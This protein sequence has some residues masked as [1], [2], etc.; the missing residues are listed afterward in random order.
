MRIQTNTKWRQTV[1]AVLAFCLIIWNVRSLQA[2]GMPV[3]DRLQPVTSGINAP[4]AVALDK[5]GSLYVAESI[6]KRVHIYSQGG[7]LKQTIQGFKS[8]VSV[9]V[10]DFGRIYVGDK[11]GGYVAVYD[12]GLGFQFK[13]G[14]GDGEF[15][16]PTDIEI[17]ST[18]RVYVVDMGSHIVRIYSA[19]GLYEGLIGGPGSGTTPTPDGKFSKPTSI[20]ISDATGEITVLDHGLTYDSYGTLVDGARIQKFN[21]DGSFKS[22]FSKFGMDMLS[23]EMFRPQHLAMDDH[24]RMYVTDTFYNVA[25]VYGDDGDPANGDTDVYLGAVYDLDVPLRIPIGITIG[26]NNKLYIASLTANRVDVFGIETYTNMVVSPLNLTYTDSQCAVPG[27]QDVDIVNNGTAGLDWTAVTD[28]SWIN[29]SS[30]SGSAPVSGASSLSIGADPDGLPAGQYSGTVRVTAASGDTEII[31]VELTAE[32]VQLI[33]SAGGPYTGTEGQAVILDASSSGG[34]I[35]SY[36]WDIGSDGTYEYSSAFPTQLHNFASNGL[37]D[38]T[39]RISGNAGQSEYAT[40]TAAISDAVPDAHFT[41]DPVT[42]T[43][44][45]TVYFS[46]SSSGYDQPLTY[47]WDFNC[48]AV[49]D[50]TDSDPSHTYEAG[51]YSVCLTVRDGDG[52]LSLLTRSDYITAG[53]SGCETPPVKMGGGYYSTLQD[54]YDDAADGAVISSRAGS[55][56]GN[57]IVDRNIS[58]SLSGGYDCSYSVSI[59]NTIL[60]GDVTMSSGALSIG[61]FFLQ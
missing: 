37:Y 4:T 58:I 29:L 54:A 51:T 38:I 41:G 60:N 22:S 31:Q 2:A 36:E 11:T 56:S 10:D 59:G 12:A 48:D 25:L 5:H 1:L 13:L 35:S 39:L 8:P 45:L 9:A 55:L 16:Q 50:S 30:S 20:E 23:G 24:G 28:E 52:S 3:Y 17:D 33:A 18:G 49:T 44:P 34:C 42:G 32:Q 40:A 47:E 53:M 26:K 19:E 21:P 27:L 46:N 6:N 7:I 43:A 57:L 15:V 14:A 61:G